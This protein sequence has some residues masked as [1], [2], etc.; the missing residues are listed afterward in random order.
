MAS[1]PSDN[2]PAVECS[3]VQKLFPIRDS[4]TVLQWY[5]PELTVQRGEKV[6]ISGPSGCGKTTLV[7]LLAGLLLPDSGQV[8]VEGVRVDQLSTAEAD[9]FRGNH[10][11]LVFQSLQL[12]RPLTVMDNLL[13]GALYG[14]RWGHAEAQERAEALLEQVGLTERRHYRAAKLSLGEQQRVAVARALINEP[15]VVL[16]DEPTA[17][18]DARNAEAVLEL[19]L[20]LC[21]QH[22]ATLLVVTHNPA[23]AP[24][25]QRQLDAGAWISSLSREVAAHV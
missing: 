5:L 15:P 19:L 17:S 12:L 9:V 18:L 1:L 13:L 8:T 2:L 14:R 3:Q 21:A 25:F 24:H 22:G 20:G 11:G 16:A 23:L 6:M 10:L 7:N 4:D